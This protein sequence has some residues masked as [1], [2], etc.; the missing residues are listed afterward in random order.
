VPTLSVEDA[1]R[2]Y[3]AGSVVRVHFN[4]ANPRDAVLSTSPTTSALLG[5]GLGALCLVG[6]VLI[7]ARSR[8]P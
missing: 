4:P 3:V 2:K 7:L 1:Q 5:F 6:A 8:G